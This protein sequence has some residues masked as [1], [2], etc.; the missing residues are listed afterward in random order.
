MTASTLRVLL[1]PLLGVLLAA[2]AFSAAQSQADKK[3]LPSLDSLKAARFESA[4][5]AG[6]AP[7]VSYSD[8]QEVITASKACAHGLNLLTRYHD[9]IITRGATGISVFKSVSPSVVLVLTGNFKGDELSEVGVGTGVIVDAA[10][11]VLTNWHVIAGYEAAV[12]FLK[13]ATGTDI[14]RQNAYGAAAVAWDASTDLALLRMVKPPA[15]LRPIRMGDIGAVQVAE[16][17]HIIGHP[18]SNLWSYSTGVISQIR[19]PYAWNYSDGSHHQAKVL[20][21]QTAINPGNS[22]GPVLDDN[23][24]LLGLVAMSEEG[25]NLNYAV[26]VDVIRVFVS[27]SLASRTRGGAAKGADHTAEWSSAHLTD[28]RVVLKATYRDLSAYEIRGANGHLVGLVAQ[29]SDG[30]VLRAV[31]PNEFGAFREW[32]VQLPD[33]KLLKATGRGDVPEMVSLE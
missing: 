19:D 28:G 33:G 14:S 8:L 10:G 11:Y 29:A 27:R 5:Q 6:H 18:H 17:I 23:G 26:A 25:Q 21:M 9:P 12:I 31:N 22:G 7:A 16:D 30:T 24:N 15:G 13:P 1:R 20:Q 4:S 3:D 32:T 2:Q